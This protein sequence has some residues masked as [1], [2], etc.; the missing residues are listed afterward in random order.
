MFLKNLP[1]PQNTSSE[2]FTD[3]FYQIFNEWVIPNIEK[4]EMSPDFYETNITLQQA[5]E[6]MT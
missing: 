4:N 2:S 1:P 6:S 5:N 3:E